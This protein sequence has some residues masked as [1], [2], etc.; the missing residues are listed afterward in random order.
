MSL[1]LLKE[2]FNEKPIGIQY[3]EEIED[4]EQ[5][6]ERLENETHDLSKQISILKKE[7]NILLHELDKARHFEEGVFDIKEKDYINELQSKEY[8]IK[9]IKSEFNPLY[10]KIDK[11]KDR[12]FYQDDVIKKYINKNKELNENI[13]KL[14]Y[15]LNSE[16]KNSKEVISEIELE[17]KRTY[18]DYIND[19][20]AYENTLISKNEIISSHKNKLKESLD[21]LKDASNLIINLKKDI[22]INE[23]TRQDLKEK[24]EKISNL[25]GEVYSLSKEV[26]HL[27]SLF[28]ENNILYEDEI[29]YKNNDMDKQKQ[30]LEENTKKIKKLNTK[31]NNLESK[32]KESEKIISEKTS[33]LSEFAVENS[34]LQTQLEKAESFQNIISNK[35][36]KFEKS[37]KETSNSNVFNV[38]NLLTTVSRKKQGNQILTWNKWLDIPENNY[39]LNLDEA[40]AKKIFNQS[41]R[42]IQEKK[43]DHK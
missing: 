33:A 15:R 19:L 35:K 2:M 14:N 42:L 1:E 9:E 37:I 6:I 18:Q 38:I 27:S 30:K 43:N 7:K 17:R 21:K 24:N 40:I 11:Q 39:L 22:K 13:N 25:N 23:N 10:K 34:L 16:K 26:K 36:D 31:I 8:T 3:E 28:N 29:K 5:I 12:L 20:D 41:N 4:K 32:N